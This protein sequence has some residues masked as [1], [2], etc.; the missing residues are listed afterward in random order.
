MA[1][2]PSFLLYFAFA[3]LLCT[4]IAVPLLETEGT[5]DESEKVKYPMSAATLI[6][7]G[8]GSSLGI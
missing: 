5:K 4:V 1:A 2:Q 6:M 7:R 3:T 8:I